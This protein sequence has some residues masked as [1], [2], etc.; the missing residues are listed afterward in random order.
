MQ[1]EISP[2]LFNQELVCPFCAYKGRLIEFRIKKS[3]KSK[4]YSTKLFQCPDCGQRMHRE[5][6]LKEMTVSEWARWMYNDVIR[7]E[8]GYER[9]SWDKLRGPEGRLKKY[10][11]ATEFWEAFKAAKAG[12]QRSD[13]EDFTDYL[14][15]AAKEAREICP[16]WQQRLAGK[17]SVVCTQCPD[18]KICWGAPE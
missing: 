10:G 1:V 3:E 16:K 6:L 4:E 5:T 14:R 7:Y 18:W 9:I 13:I 17:T 11:W 15:Y 8:G 12:R 2:D